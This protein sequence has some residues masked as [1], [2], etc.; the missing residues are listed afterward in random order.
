M[1][2]TSD[3]LQWVDESARGY[4]IA[5]RIL[6][7]ALLIHSA[8]FV[9]IAV[10]YAPYLS[11]QGPSGADRVF[12]YVYTRSIVI[13]GDLRFENDLAIHPPTSGLK[14]LHGRQINMRPIGSGLLALPL[15]EL[16]HLMVLAS[17]Q[18]G[19]PY[20]PADGFSLPYV[21]SYLASEMFFALLGIWLL[22]RTLLRYVSAPVAALAVVGYWFATN[23][24][25]WTSTDLM[26]SH[27]AAQ[28]SIAWCSF[29][30]VRLREKP[31]SRTRWL[32]VGV[33]FALVVMVRYQNAVFGLVPV[34]A[35]VC[36]LK[37]AIREQK[38][39]RVL[40]CLGAAVAGCVIAFFP[41]M[42]VWRL[43]FGSW[44]TNSY[45]LDTNKLNFFKPH[46]VEIL[47]NPPISGLSVWLP[48]LSVG[49][50]GCFL[51][52]FCRRDIIA[53]ASG[54]SWL[55]HLY[56]IA[57]WSAWFTLVE[58]CPFDFN[59]PISLGFAFFL[60]TAGRRWPRATLIAL[61]LLVAWNIPL[62]VLTPTPTFPFGW[63]QSVKI[64][65]G[66]SK[67]ARLW[68]A[69]TGPGTTSTR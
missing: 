69:R 55:I 60:S 34:A 5:R 37:T 36:A 20:A 46:L 16:T 32:G 67:V 21:L 2:A 63:T 13:D 64:L 47:T 26:M 27:A 58:R 14:T 18:L 52:A 40:S 41:Q 59:F 62:A 49:I 19:G 35:G 29:E 33:S 17:N 44:I 30:S 38:A 48:G 7:F 15:F 43:V 12:F 1:S 25:R 39:H 45:S 42:L 57:S 6:L 28:F 54:F 68:E 31:L 50:I 53:L 23:A 51:L 61:S 66:V 9:R 4:H 65:T 10:L 8:V 22:Y 24:V 56:V 11:Y 3:T